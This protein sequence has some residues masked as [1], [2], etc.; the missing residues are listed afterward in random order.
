MFIAYGGKEMTKEVIENLNIL[1]FHYH[2][3]VMKNDNV[4]ERIIYSVTAVQ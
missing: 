4:N 3:N 2:G 1:R